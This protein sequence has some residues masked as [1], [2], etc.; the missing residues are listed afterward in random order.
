MQVTG[1]VALRLYLQGSAY[2]LWMFGRLQEVRGVASGVEDEVQC[3]VQEHGGSGAV[4][5]ILFGGPGKSLLVAERFGEVVWV[6][7]V[8]WAVGWGA[9]GGRGIVCEALE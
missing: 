2:C 5:W 3:L 9:A 7:A 4:G 6:D 1:R 8:W